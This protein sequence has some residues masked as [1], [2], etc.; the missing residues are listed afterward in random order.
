MTVA[1]R[2]LGLLANLPAA[3][4]ADV[5]VERDLPAKMADGV[6]LLADRWYPASSD[7][8]NPPVILL[9][10]PY[11]RR[12]WAGGIGRLFAERRYQVVIQ[13]CRGTFG[14]G[15]E[16]VPFR[17]EEADG[18]STLDWIT[19]QSWFSGRTA[20][21]GPSYLGLTQ[22]AVAQDPPEHLKAMALDVTASDFRS[23]VVYPSDC[24]ALGTSLAWAR[25]L[26][27]QERRPFEVLRSQLK[28]RQALTKAATVLPA[29]AADL[30]ATG[31]RV[32]FFQDWLSHEGPHDTWWDPMNFGHRLGNVPPATLVGGWYDIFLPSQLADYRA[33]RAAGRDA[34]LTVG[35]WTHTSPGTIAASLRDALEWFDHHLGQKTDRERSP[36]V[37]I[38]VMGSG[39]W[40]ELPEWPPP[41]DE[42]LWYL[43]GNGTLGLSTPHD[44]GPDRYRYDPGH[45][46]PAVGGPALDWGD[47]GR[48]D[49]HT[50]ETRPDVLTYSSAYLTENLTVIG[51]IAADIHVRSSLEHSDFFVRLCDVSPRGRSRNVSD[52]I[53]RLAPGS[54]AT[55]PDGSIRIGIDMWP[56]AHT[57]VRG[58]RIRLQV[59]S[60]AHPLFMRN[61]GTGEPVGSAD[62]LCVADQEVFHDPE[63][64]SVLRLPVTQI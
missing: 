21:F 8:R 52:G 1:S 49:Q 38:Y 43:G 47:S 18:R 11:G 59:S 32:P 12:Q 15:G 3:T 28:S 44:D 19:R 37:R 41:A 31:G 57:F 55:S 61:T 62:R 48:K 20:T 53:I 7:D 36:R 13:S 6:V 16:W 54:V 9:R 2:I 26:E 30:V 39:R 27:Y 29:S 10:T 42:Q 51:P 60:G 40:V 34:R 17:H 56:T 45:P 46:T 4:T 64:P 5:S 50:R 14:S 23:S 24:F 63:H 22:W 33:L 58:H 25:Q 35:P